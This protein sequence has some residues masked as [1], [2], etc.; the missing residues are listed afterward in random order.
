[1]TTDYQPP[2]WINKP[3]SELTQQQ[4][5]AL[6]DG[7]G[8]CCLHKYFADPDDIEERQFNPDIPENL[9]NHPYVY[10]QMTCEL[11]SVDKCGCTDYH[12]RQQR[13][14]DCVP[15]NPETVATLDWLPTTCAYKLRL[16]NRPLQEWHPLVSGSPETVKDAGAAISAWAVEFNHKE[17][18]LD[19]LIDFIP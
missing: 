8:K 11:Y 14:P 3:L 7:C 9:K 12:N 15:L 6:C 4:W 2:D 5:E 1:M 19:Y 17:D 16:E 18:P 13:M 10:S